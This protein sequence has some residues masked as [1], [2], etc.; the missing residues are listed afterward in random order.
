M[1]CASFF[2]LGEVIIKQLTISIKIPNEG[3]FIMLWRVGFHSYCFSPSLSLPFFVS[4]LHFLGWDTVL[5]ER[6]TGKDGLFLPSIR[7]H[8]LSTQLCLCVLAKSFQLCL[9]LC[10]PM[11]CS[12]PG[13]S[14]HGILQ[15]R[16]LEWVA[17]PS[18]GG[19]SRPRNRTSVS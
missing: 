12:P 6:N 8:I 14:V 9:T 1:L 4:A 2:F 13:S 7:P 3:I 18:S 15:A 16:I 19:S 10:N 17:M 5:T 11:D